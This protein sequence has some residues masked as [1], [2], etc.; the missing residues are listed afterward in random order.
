M[1]G[2]YERAAR[3][4]LSAMP[5]R[6]PTAYVINGRLYPAYKSGHRSRAAQTWRL[7]WR[8][9]AIRAKIEVK[10]EK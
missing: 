6:V 10:E 7:F 3:R 5:R 1:T 8:L 9:K 4:L 2:A